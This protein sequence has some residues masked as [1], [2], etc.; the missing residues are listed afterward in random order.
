[1]KVDANIS[2]KQLQAS[3]PCAFCRATASVAME[4]LLSGATVTC[5]S[6]DAALS[7][8]MGLSPASLDTLRQVLAL[9]EAAVGDLST[10]DGVRPATDGDADVRPRRRRARRSR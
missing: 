5:P 1:M 10:R 2:C 9:S 6:C 3:V 7:L 4:D 8:D